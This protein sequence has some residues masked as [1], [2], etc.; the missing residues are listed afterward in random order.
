MRSFLIALQFLT[1]IPIKIREVK[2]EDIGKS[3]TCFPL[4]G[5]FIGLLL[6]ISV[7]LFSPLPS[8]VIAVLVLIVSILVTGAIHL[9]GFADT[10]DGFYGAKPKEEI[11]R[12]MRDSHV[13]TMGIV[14]VFC[15]LALK[16]AILTSIPKLD[17]F[18]ALILMITF[19]RW[20]QVLACSVSSYARDEGKAKYFIKYSGKKELVIATFFTLALFL[21]LLGAK[22]LM[23]FI[24]SSL[25]IFLFINYLKKRIDGMTGDT[26]GATN[27]VAEVLVILLLLF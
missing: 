1:N 23:L 14:G 5:A 21:L 17:L 10:C 13:G 18:G 19:G 9:D 6:A 15:L 8:L 20:S 24:V 12:I 26:I 11:L 22:G 16:I 3:L 4:V 25:V 2:E 7:T 27:E